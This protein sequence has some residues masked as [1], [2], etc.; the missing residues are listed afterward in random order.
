MGS[1]EPPATLPPADEPVQTPPAGAVIPATVDFVSLDELQSGHRL[2][3]GFLGAATP[4]MLRRRSPEGEGPQLHSPGEALLQYCLQFFSSPV[5]NA[6]VPASP[7]AA[8]TFRLN[9]SLLSNPAFIA[10]VQSN[11]SSVGANHR[12]LGSTGRLSLKIKRTRAMAKKWCANARS[13][14]VLAQ[15][16]IVT[17]RFLDKLEEVRPLSPIERSLRIEVKLS[18]HRQNATL[19]AHWRNALRLKTVSLVTKTLLIFICVPRFD[20]ARIKSK[21]SH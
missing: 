5:C 21:P 16:C 12:H 19:A 14:S 6:L 2:R 3:L 10:K 15:N 4:A 11:W 18:L 17:I 13:P 9:N 7:L 1:P 8:S 20:I